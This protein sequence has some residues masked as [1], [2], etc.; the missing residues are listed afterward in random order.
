M[1]QQVTAFTWD[2]W[3]VYAEKFHSLHD[4]SVHAWMTYTKIWEI[5][6]Q[7]I[8]SEICITSPFTHIKNNIW[9]E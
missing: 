4:F 7:K 5:F 3:I 9:T 6:D 1:S 8:N 2:F